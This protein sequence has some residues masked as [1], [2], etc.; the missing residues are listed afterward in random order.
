MKLGWDR[1]ARIAEHIFDSIGLTPL[2]RL[3]R[4]GGGGPA[5][6]SPASE[7]G[8]AMAAGRVRPL[9]AGGNSALQGRVDWT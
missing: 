1:N 5:R 4:L 7:P 2:V 8:A 9:P 6:P 3:G